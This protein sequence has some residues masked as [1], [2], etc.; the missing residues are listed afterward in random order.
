MS[1]SHVSKWE[2]CTWSPVAPVHQ[3]VLPL[4]DGAELSGPVAVL[5]LVHKEVDAL[6]HQVLLHPAQHVLVAQQHLQHRREAMGRSCQQGRSGGQA[7]GCGRRGS[8]T[9]TSRIRHAGKQHARQGGEPREHTD[10]HEHSQSRS[11][12]SGLPNCSPFWNLKKFWIF[13]FCN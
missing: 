9:C 6:P 8:Q 13:I 7:G 10:R 2:A 1:R 11:L 12:T 3:L 5:L 4:Y